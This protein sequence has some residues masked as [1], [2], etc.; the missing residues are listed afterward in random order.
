MYTTK[1]GHPQ[2]NLLPQIDSV[3]NEIFNTTINHAT[4]EKS[5]KYSQPSAN[6]KEFKEGFEIYLALPG[7]QKSDVSITVEKNVLVIA[8]EKE[9]ELAD[10]FKLRE[11]HYGVFTRRFKLPKTLDLATVNASLKNG[12]LTVRIEKRPD[13]VDNGPIEIKVD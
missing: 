9:N 10:K 2:N 12:V 13:E 11:F 1:N 3:L 4:D 5:K 6:V 7:Y 8:S